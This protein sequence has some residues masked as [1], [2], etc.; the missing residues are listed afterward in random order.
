MSTSDT[1]RALIARIA[2]HASWARTEDRTARTAPAR[3]GLMEKFRQQV[4]PDGV[5]DPGE[6]ERRAESARR[7]FYLDMARK[8]AAKRRQNAADAAELAALRARSTA[9]PPSPRTRGTVTLSR[10]TG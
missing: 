10:S 7:A 1:D 5:L 8:S 9:C 3:A 2:S 6:R 4:D